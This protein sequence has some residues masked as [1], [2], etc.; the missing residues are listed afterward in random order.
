MEWASSSGNTYGCTLGFSAWRNTAAGWQ[1]TFVTAAHCSSRRGEL[2]N[3]PFYQAVRRSSAYIGKEIL[4]PPFTTDTFNCE[5]NYLCRWSDALLGL[6]ERDR[7]SYGRI[8]RTSL[9][10]P[11][12]INSTYPEYNIAGEISYP[13]WGEILHKQGYVAGWQSGK[14][15]QTCIFSYP[16]VGKQLACQD[17]FDIRAAEG[18]SGGP[19]FSMHP[20]ASGWVYLRGILWGSAGGMSAWYNI[21]RDLGTLY[22]YDCVEGNPD[23]PNC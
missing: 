14:I 5:A 18:D 2:D 7:W 20:T 6:W 3:T 19:V 1:Q 22:A 9:S 21:E 10:F 8:A 17:I 11:T 23:F 12:T 16:Q 4:D 15:S 13:E